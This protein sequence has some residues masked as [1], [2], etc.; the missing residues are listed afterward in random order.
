MNF[1][2][3]VN[4]NTTIYT[5]QK[6]IQD[7][8]GRIKDLML[9]KDGIVKEENEMSCSSFRS[10][11]DSGG[12]GGVDS[13]PSSDIGVSSHSSSNNSE[14][15]TLKEYGIVGGLMK[16]DAPTYSLC[17]DFKPVTDCRDPILLSWVG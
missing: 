4:I 14:M 1:Q 2:I 10:G 16:D 11:G 8:H 6:L 7:K 12:G 9:Y 13:H 17:Y 5:I 15:K 3:T